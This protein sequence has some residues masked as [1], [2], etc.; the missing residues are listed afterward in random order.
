MT[1]N[2]VCL[3]SPSLSFLN[4]KLLLTEKKLISVADDLFGRKKRVQSAKAALEQKR[5]RNQRDGTKRRRLKQKKSELAGT[6]SR[7]TLAP[8]SEPFRGCD[9][10]AGKSQNCD[11]PQ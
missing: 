1:L 6:V 2:F 5:G 3:F 8:D 4:L 9:L 7:W 11:H 10:Y